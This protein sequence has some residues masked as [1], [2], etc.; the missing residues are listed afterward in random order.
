MKNVDVKKLLVFILIIVAIGIIGF[1]AFK[2]LGK[3]KI[4][5]EEK[6]IIENLGFNYYVNMSRDYSSFYGGLDYLF[7][8]DKV[9]YDDLDTGAILNTALTYAQ[10]NNLNLTIQSGY[11][12][13]LEDE[14]LYGDLDN[15]GIYNAQGI[16]DA[17]KELFGVE[18]DNKSSINTLNFMYDFYYDGLF[19]LYLVMRNDVMDYTDSNRSMNY[20][21]IETTKKDNKL[22]TTFALGYIY[23]D[24]NTMSIAKDP[25]GEEIV[26]ENTSSVELPDDKL[27]SFNKYTLTLKQTDDKKYVFE[28]IEK[29]N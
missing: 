26:V 22:L 23:G 29:Q 25:S 7:S 8:K 27:D 12:D 11:M 1:V 4:S 9:T 18:W 5:D 17:I 10:D 16:R 20:K 6:E 21:I 13:G 19:D 3:D 28:S 14:N 15:Y 24:G 2:S